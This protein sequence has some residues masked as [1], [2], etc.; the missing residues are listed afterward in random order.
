MGFVKCYKYWH[1]TQIACIWQVH[2][3]IFIRLAASVSMACFKSKFFCLFE[4]LKFNHFSHK[5][6]E[7]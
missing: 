7:Y 1:I 6:V 5:Y 2:V 3:N 4:I